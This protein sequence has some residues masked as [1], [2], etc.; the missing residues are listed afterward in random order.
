MS[1]YFQRLVRYF[2][3]IKHT[4]AKIKKR[5]WVILLCS[6]VFISGLI[7]LLIFLN[8]FSQNLVND[9]GLGIGIL[10][11]AMYAL[12]GVDLYLFFVLIISFVG[13]I[14]SKFL[15]KEELKLAFKYQSW[16]WLL[17]WMCFTIYWLTV[18]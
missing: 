18:R 7:C 3:N 17:V 5:Y 10:A 8:N 6:I 13:F 4:M 2:T 12:F 16:T 14:I 15:K 1:R 11:S 9:N